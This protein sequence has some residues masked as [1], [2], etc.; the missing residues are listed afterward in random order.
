MIRSFF[1]LPTRTTST[2][3][4]RSFCETALLPFLTALIAAS[5]IMFARSA[6]T[7]PEVARAISL[8]S[9]VSSKSTSLECTFKILILPFRSG[10]S[11]TTRRSKR[12]GRRSAGSRISGRLVAP[13]TRSPFVESKP[14]ISER[15]W[16]KVCS[17]HHFRPCG[18]RGCGR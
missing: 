18:C 9:T 3:S 7:A 8:K 11:T 17:S 6:P 15:S 13:K 16:F 14:S 2:A 5:F 10:L 12:P 4:K 1:S